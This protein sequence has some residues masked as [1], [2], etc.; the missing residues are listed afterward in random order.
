[1]RGEPVAINRDMKFPAE[2]FEPANVIP[3]LVRQEHA[4]ELR[5]RD[6]AL[7]EAD[8]DLSRAQSAIDQ[9]PAM[10]GRDQS[11]ISCAAAAEHGQ[12]EHARLVADPTPI[13][14][15]EMIFVRKNCE[16]T[17]A[18]RQFSSLATP[19]RAPFLRRNRESERRGSPRGGAGR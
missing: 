13:H 17:R 1:F 18:A 16:L 14:K 2:H 15:S 10:I 5:R 9:N 3:V 19:E 12:S 7:L 6:S 11:A 8:D 4:I